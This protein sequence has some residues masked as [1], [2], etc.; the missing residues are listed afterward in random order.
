[1]KK[2]NKKNLYKL[3]RD[4]SDVTGIAEMTIM[5]LESFIESIRQL[6]CT[7]KQAEPLYFELAETVRHSQPNIV[8]LM[9]LLEQFEAEMEKTLK[10]DMTVETVGHNAIVSLQEKIAQFKYNAKRVTQNGLNYI[11]NGDVIVVH[12]PS[13]VVNNILVTAKEKL[14]KQ[15][16]VIILDHNQVRTHKTVGLLRDANIEHIVTPAHNLSHHIETA[17]KMFL[18][19]LTITSD[20]QI[21]APL[22][23]AGTV[24]L[25]HFNNIEVHLF[26]NTLHYS[27]RKATDQFIYKAEE[28]PS[29]ANMDFSVTTHSHDLVSL[30]MIDHVITEHGETEKKE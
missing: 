26:A 6:K 11:N 12:S 16:S 21:V 1:M 22:G 15:F 20:Q 3:F 23:T 10:S 18:G 5:C 19:A 29:G 13:T 27:H 30:D 14:G 9:H 28:D 4:L 25:C 7:Q 8:P 24:S 17:N 2:E